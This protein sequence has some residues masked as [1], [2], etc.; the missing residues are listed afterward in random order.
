M[1]RPGFTLGHNI[2]S[3]DAPLPAIS[4]P[5]PAPAPSQGFSS[6]SHFTCARHMPLSFSTKRRQRRINTRQVASFWSTSGPAPL[7]TRC[8]TS[9]T[10]LFKRSKRGCYSKSTASSTDKLRL[11]KSIC[12]E[13]RPSLSWLVKTSWGTKFKGLTSSSKFFCFWHSEVSAV[14]K[15]CDLEYC[16]MSAFWNR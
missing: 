8:V 14:R 12:V 2:S 7:V 15:S 1:I 4:A 16:R 5:Y 6:R 13:K 10:C 9:C 11:S 3:A